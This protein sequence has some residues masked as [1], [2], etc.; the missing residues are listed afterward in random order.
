MEME[1]LCR[2]YTKPAVIQDI[3]SKLQE[4]VK[5]SDADLIKM[6]FRSLSNKV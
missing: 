2:H 6:L 5:G 4:L 3:E 1:F